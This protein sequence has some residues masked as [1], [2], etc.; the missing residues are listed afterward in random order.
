MR[1]LLSAL[2]LTLTLTLTLTSCR[3]F[4]EP[5]VKDVSKFNVNRE[6]GKGIRF[7]IGMNVENPNRYRITV[8]D[9]NLDVMINEQVIGNTRTPFK[10]Y[11][12]QKETA[13]FSI[14]VYTDLKK[15]FGGLMNMFSG[16]TS[17]EK[18]VTLRLKGHL[19]ARALTVTK[20]F[21]VDYQKPVLFG[22]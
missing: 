6:E 11:I 20:R 4:Y 10:Q 16:L 2:V 18:T 5:V 17:K 12:R 8:V 3:P 22:L 7:D 19:T 15:M 9:M 14:A 13:L 21:A 1:F